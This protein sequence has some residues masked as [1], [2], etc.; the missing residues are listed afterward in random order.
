MTAANSIQ[1]AVRVYEAVGEPWSPQIDA[2]MSSSV[3]KKS[4]I[5]LS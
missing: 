4:K 5:L 1:S 2:K 3:N